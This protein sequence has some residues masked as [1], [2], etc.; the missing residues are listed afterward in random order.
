[1]LALALADAG[2][3]AL[4][5][6][7]YASSRVS[8]A[9]GPT[10][11]LSAAFAPK[12]LGAPT[13]VSFAVNIDPPAATGPIPLSAVAVSYPSDLGLATSGLGLASCEPI[14][15]EFEGAEVCPP[16]SKMGQGSAL[17]EVPF[18][19]EIVKETVTLGLYAAPSSD[20]YVH[21]AILAHG[22]EPVAASVVMSG[23]LRAG[24]LDITI[25]AIASLPGAPY[26]AL[27]SLRASLGGALTY[28]ERIHGR[29]VA[30]RPRGIGLPDSC[31]RGGWKLAAA[32]TFAD[33]RS[34]HAS[35]AV[36]C[37]RGRAGRRR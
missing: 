12:R 24:R 18:G 8:I 2:G 6:A 32:F 33:G 14:A 13:I 7:T 10:A 19:P 16:N 37:P 25:P 1:M 4:A 26:V 15:L 30:Y 17:V 22:S 28:Y 36:A 20:G 27:V 5:P 3:A 23:V 35:T 34:S 31:P 21:L 29:V 9:S 11:R